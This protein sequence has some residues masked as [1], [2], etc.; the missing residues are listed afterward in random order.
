VE[1]REFVA[2]SREAWERLAHTVA[3]ARKQGVSRLD[4]PTLKT[5][6]EDYRR[7]AADLAY[8]QTH[9]PRSE[10]VLYLNRLVAQAHGELYG[11]APNRVGSLWRFLS[12]DYPQLVR[13]RWRPIAVSAALLFGAMLLGFLLVYVDYPLARVFLPQQFQEG[14]G[15]AAE[16]GARTSL[17]EA[18]LASAAITVNNIEVAF[19]AFAGGMSFGALTVY[20]LIMNGLLV[21]AL[22][23]VF[24]KGGLSLLFWSLIVPHGSLE[25]PA[26]VLAGAAGLLLASALLFP[27]DLRRGA[28]LRAV[29][30]DAGR[31]VLGVI[32]LLIVAGFIEGFLTPRGFDPTLKL[33]F[34][35]LV[36]VLFVLWVT[37]AGR[38]H[39][40]A[41]QAA[42]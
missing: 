1:E 29:S 38:S 32:P 37:L 27:G 17:P 2:G 26:I 5:M 21:G 42:E 24:T 40:P 8:A 18:P 4:V 11:G 13:S 7:A 36:G 22:S 14:V 23:G 3:I 31:L 16:R 30:G 39:V 9:F 35:A 6:H 34:A 15:D 12:R 33:V 20:A 41:E 25:L 28:A 19:L 10:T